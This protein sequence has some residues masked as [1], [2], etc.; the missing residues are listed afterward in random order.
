[1]VACSSSKRSSS[2]DSFFGA[3]SGTANVASSMVTTMTPHARNSSSSRWGMAKGI[4]N[5]TAS[6]MV[7]FGPASVMIAVERSSSIVMRPVR[8]RWM[9]SMASTHANLTAS[10][11]SVIPNM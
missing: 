7:P 10:I 2:T 1:M 11:S 6:V 5:A 4:V 9:R 3:I 8:C